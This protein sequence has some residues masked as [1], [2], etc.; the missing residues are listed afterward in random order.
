MKKNKMITV[1]V[2]IVAIV[3]TVIAATSATTP[4]WEYTYFWPKNDPGVN[5]SQ[6]MSRLNEMGDQGWELISVNA[7]NGSWLDSACYILRRS[8]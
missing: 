5:M 2:A 1:A 6:I 4:R 8:K 7:H 3:G